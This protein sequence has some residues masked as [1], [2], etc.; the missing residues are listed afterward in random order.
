MI[1]YYG[2]RRRAMKIESKKMANNQ[3]ARWVLQPNAGS[4]LKEHC[5]NSSVNALKPPLTSSNAY[6]STKKQRSFIYATA[7]H[8]SAKSAMNK[9]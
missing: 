8:L 1:V 7:A 9:I 4:N 3:S 2:A 6:P 5:R